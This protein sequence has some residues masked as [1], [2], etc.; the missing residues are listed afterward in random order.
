GRSASEDP[1]I[2]MVE[3]LGYFVQ[4]YPDSLN[5]VDPGT[6]LLPFLQ[7]SAEAAKERIDNS[8]SSVHEEFPLSIVYLLLR[9]EPS[10]VQAS[11]GS[12]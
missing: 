1:L 8:Q 3:I 12:R 9:E 11:V 10:L 4:L 5:V 6:N 7:A 2:Q